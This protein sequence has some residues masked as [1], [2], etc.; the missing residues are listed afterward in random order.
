MIVWD[1]CI[2][3]YF[4]KNKEIQTLH[5]PTQC[6]F[7]KYLPVVL[8]VELESKEFTYNLT[9]YFTMRKFIIPNNYNSTDIKWLST[10]LSLNTISQLLNSFPYIQSSLITR[11]VLVTFNKRSPTKKCSGASGRG[12]FESL[13]K[14]K[15]GREFQHNFICDNVVDD[16]T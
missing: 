11:N 7:K 16:I 4:Y 15:I 6:S 8:I 12:S 3:Y 2:Y 14:Y 5:S 13:L 9:N 1:V 10:N